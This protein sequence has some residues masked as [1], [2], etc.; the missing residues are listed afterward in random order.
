MIY[1]PERLR[2][3]LIRAGAKGEGIFRPASWEEALDKAADGFRKAAGQY[4]PQALASYFGQGVLEDAIGKAGEQF[5][6][7]L[8]SPNDMNCG[9]ICNVVSSVIAPVTTVGVPKFYMVQDLEHCDAVFVW[10]KNPKTDDGPAGIYRRIRAA[11]ARGAKVVVIDPRKTGAGEIADLWVPVIPGSDGALALAMLQAIWERDGF[12]REIIDRH[13]LDFDAFAARLRALDRKALLQVCGVSPEVLEHLV[14][15][16]C[17]TP[18][19]P[20]ISYTGLEY[21][22]SGVQNLR[23]IHLLW[24]L[25]GKLDVEGGVYLDAWG[26][27]ERQLHGTDSQYPP[28]G[29]DTFPVFTAFTGRGQFSC[30]PRAV[31]ESHPYPVR[32]LLLVGGSPI[33]TYP[34]SAVW[35]QTYQALD[36]FVILDRCMTEDARY[37][38]VVLPASTWYENASVLEL[39]DGW[40]LREPLIEPVGEARHDVFILQALAQRLGFG[41]TLPATPEELQLWALGGDRA[42]YERLKASN[43]IPVCTP[44]RPRV[45]RKYD[46]G[47]L[48]QD[49]KPGFPTPS[50][51]I[52]PCS[53]LLES[54]G[55]SGW[56]EY[57][58]IR[59]ATGLDQNTYPFLLTSGSRGIMHI[60]AFGPNIPAM[61]QADPAPWVELSPEDAE[62]LHLTDGMP[63]RVVSPYGE[64]VFPVRIASMA[65]RSIHIPFGGGS[66]FMAS[67]WASGNVND[68]CTLYSADPISGF[69]TVKSVP[70]RLEFIKSAEYLS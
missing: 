8:G 56:P 39:K 69:V 11:Q 17:S 63:V 53:S 68:L 12:D 44:E 55:Y 54:F 28:L 67:P 18:R 47:L 57:Q 41:D 50:G 23:A 42:L 48:R 51:K 10:G 58:D 70:C 66:S 20:L 19:I 2:T 43:G 65:R 36:H 3:P 34:D 26:L 22:C 35:R 52:E 38:D 6:A 16:L 32:G 27:S 30:L 40:Q 7:H 49:G 4:G 24:A 5:F 21:Q 25:T 1:G 62:E 59:H 13:T 15:L 60:G 31:L 61:A 46:L 45:Y 29:S 64:K 14:N 9:S 33:V 37:A